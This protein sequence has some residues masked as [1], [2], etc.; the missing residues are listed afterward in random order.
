MDRAKFDAS[1]AG[2]QIFFKTKFQENN[3]MAE[4][5]EKCKSHRVPPVLDQNNYDSP[6]EEEIIVIFSMAIFAV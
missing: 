6:R 2:C 4:K 5:P 1:A 3:S